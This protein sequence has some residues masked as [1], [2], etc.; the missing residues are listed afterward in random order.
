MATLRGRFPDIALPDV[1]QL[2]QANRRTGELLVQRHDRNGILF[3]LRGEVVNARSGDA[4]GEPAAFEILEWEG[5]EFEFVAT[6]VAVERVIR[7]TVPDLLIE[8]ARSADSRKH[9]SGIFADP[10]L[11]PWLRLPRGARPGEL[12]LSEEESPVLPFLDGFHTLPEVIAGSGV[13][14]IAV[15]ELCH[16]LRNDGRLELLNPTIGVDTAPTK[17]SFLQGGAGS[18]LF[19]ANEA[20]WRAMQGLWG[21]EH[22]A[23]TLARGLEARWRSMGPYGER[24]IERIRLALPAGALTMP[25]EFVKGQDEDKVALPGDLLETWKVPAGTRVFVRP[26]PG[27]APRS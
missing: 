24:N 11:V 22:Q 10:T 18:R 5:G 17:P 13:R 14:D 15:F 27:E 3:V 25:V 23:C 4:Q 7:R 19:Q 2:L 1:L 8:G 26:A 16:R 6:Q 12:G 20:H 21:R 9:L